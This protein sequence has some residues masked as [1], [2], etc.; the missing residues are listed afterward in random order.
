MKLNLSMAVVAGNYSTIA[1]PEHKERLILGLGCHCNKSSAWAGYIYR[2]DPYSV[3]GIFNCNMP[4][5]KFDSKEI[6][7]DLVVSIYNDSAGA[8]EFNM[9][10]EISETLK[11][12]YVVS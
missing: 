8:L 5:F 4:H 3:V 6:C 7:R 9:F 10:I 1:I 12:K 11:N 2:G